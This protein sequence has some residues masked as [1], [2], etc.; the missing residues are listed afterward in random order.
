MMNDLIDNETK[1]QLGIATARWSD[2]ETV[3]LP[4]IVAEGRACPLP[5]TQLAPISN[6]PLKLSLGEGY[7]RV[8]AT[9]ELPIDGAVLDEKGLLERCEKESE[10]LFKNT[11]RFWVS[12]LDGIGAVIELHYDHL[13]AQRYELPGEEVLEFPAIEVDLR[14]VLRAVKDRWLRTEIEA[15]MGGEWQSVVACGLYLRYWTEGM[16]AEELRQIVECIKSGSEPPAWQVVREAVSQWN[17]EQIDTVVSYALSDAFRLRRTLAII[18]DNFAPSEEAWVWDFVNL[19]VA[20]DDIEAI[21]ELLGLLEN[22]DLDAY[23][24]ELDEEAWALVST[25][26]V[27]LD[28]THPRL[29]RA[30]GKPGDLWWTWPVRDPEDFQLFKR[31]RR[32]ER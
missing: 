17:Q 14:P 5:E 1:R 4:P 32:R 27:G 24:Q 16:L 12:R 19:C 29:I 26:P 13:K 7:L 21:R 30:L 28:L 2:V 15:Y 23:L 8:V 31:R 18:E 3:D 11:R 10:I 9:D 22:H 25:V 20:R 6:L